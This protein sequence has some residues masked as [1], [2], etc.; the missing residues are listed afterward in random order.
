M[1]EGR[2]RRKRT[3]G[4]RVSLD[5]VRIAVGKKVFHKQCKLSFRFGTVEPYIQF[6]YFENEK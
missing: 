1:T 2:A 3:V 5:A 6:V 4:D